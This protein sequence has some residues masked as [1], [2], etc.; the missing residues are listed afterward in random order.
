MLTKCDTK[1]RDEQIQLAKC[2]QPIP[3]L[4]LKKVRRIR[5]AIQYDMLVFNDS[6]KQ[7]KWEKKSATSEIF[8]FIDNL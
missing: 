7:L 2:H 8:M 4:I 3:T 1:T 6:L 5:N